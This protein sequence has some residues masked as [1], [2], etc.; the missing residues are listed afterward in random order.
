MDWHDSQ[1]SWISLSD[2][3]HNQIIKLDELSKVPNCLN[4]NLDLYSF[5][6]CPNTK[7]KSYRSTL[8][9][10]CTLEMALKLFETHDK[11]GKHDYSH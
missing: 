10:V 6:Q 4:D 7:K 5:W 2:S 11:V 8:R 9:V 3:Q 1:K